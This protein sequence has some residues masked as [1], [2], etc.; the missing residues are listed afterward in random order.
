MRKNQYKQDNQANDHVKTR[1]P[2]SDALPN[3]KPK[4]L[5]QKYAPKNDS[6]FKVISKLQESW[7]SYRVASI[8]VR[9]EKKNHRSTLVIDPSEPYIKVGNGEI[10]TF[11][12]LKYYCHKNYK[13]F[14]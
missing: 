4:W 11:K 5:S 12:Y 7:K 9:S 6:N 10:D 3:P 8:I 1:I 14:N 13:S 2:P